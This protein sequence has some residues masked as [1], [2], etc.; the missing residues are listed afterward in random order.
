[1][2]PIAL[3]VESFETSQDIAEL[4]QDQSSRIQVRGFLVKD[5]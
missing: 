1:M 3:L 5:R 2:V 4:E